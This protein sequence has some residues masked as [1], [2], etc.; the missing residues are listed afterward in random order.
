MVVGTTAGIV[1]T[2][3]IWVLSGWGTWTNLDEL[4]PFGE[5]PEPSSELSELSISLRRAS[6]LAFAAAD[7]RAVL[8]FSS[9]NSNDGTSRYPPHG[10]PARL[11]CEQTGSR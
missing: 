4:D 5:L 1:G 2:N 10:F 11:H 7:R 8:S 3:A 6:A 9:R